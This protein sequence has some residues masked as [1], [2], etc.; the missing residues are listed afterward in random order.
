MLCSTQSSQRD[1][2]GGRCLHLSKRASPSLPLPPS[3]GFVK[4]SALQEG[5]GRCE[6][7]PGS[8]PRHPC[9][10]HTCS[11]S[12]PHKAKQQGWEQPGSHH[13]ATNAVTLA[14]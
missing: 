7:E 6:P 11:S 12:P 13:T 5:A 1:G 10:P 3:I 14:V 4:K 9:H 2:G 8:E